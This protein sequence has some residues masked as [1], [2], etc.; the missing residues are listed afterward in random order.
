MLFGVTY[1]Y[2]SYDDLNLSMV[3]SYLSFFEVFESRLQSQ[4]REMFYNR[5]RTAILLILLA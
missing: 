1:L 4:W 2:L 5:Q 3:Q